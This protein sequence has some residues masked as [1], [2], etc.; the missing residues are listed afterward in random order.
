M[1]GRIDEAATA[2][3]EIY[4]SDYWRLTKIPAEPD[5]HQRF[6]TLIENAIRAYKVESVVEFGCGFWNYGK[7]VDW[8]GL[9]YD[10]FD[11]VP[12]LSDLNADACDA[13]NIRFHQLTKEA[14]L[15]RADLLICKD[16]LQHLPS[17]DVLHY[18]AIFKA[19]FPYMLIVNDI[20][21]DDNVNGPIAHGGYRALRL[22]LPPFNEACEIVDEWDAPAFGTH[23]RKQACLLRGT[24]APPGKATPGKATR[25]G[26]NESSLFRRIL[27]LVGKG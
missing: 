3:T 5:R 8:S 20:M 6:A 10:G 23:Y 26:R 24:R 12:G 21:P 9:T 11:V 7:L 19:L 13:P 22:D 27:R 14:D 4:S 17:D 1:P 15:P 2:F 25:D 16:V 18:L